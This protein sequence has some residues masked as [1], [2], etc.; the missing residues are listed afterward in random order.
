MRGFRFF[1]CHVRF[2]LRLFV[3]TFRMQ[4]GGFFMV[5]NHGLMVLRSILMLHYRSVCGQR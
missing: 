2:F 1:R 3:L 4:L 5:F